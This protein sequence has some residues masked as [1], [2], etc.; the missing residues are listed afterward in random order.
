M[1]SSSMLLAVALCGAMPVLPIFAEETSSAGQKA[2]AGPEERIER[3]VNGYLSGIQDVKKN[4]S[5]RIVSLVSIGR[6]PVSSTLA[7][8]RA[9][10]QAFKRADAF[11]R[12]EFMKWLKTSVT[13]T[14]IDHHD[15]AIAEK[16]KSSG[17]SGTSAET[18]EAGEFT[19][20]SLEIVA[21]GFV[22]GMVQI[23]AGINDDNEAVVILGWN[24]DT[25]EQTDAIRDWNSTRKSKA[26]DRATG[27]EVKP[28][29]V[30]T[31]T[32]DA[33]GDFL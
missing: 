30:R 32:S 22:K 8:A 25:A 12:A 18:S 28:P 6:A 23:G 1:R 24:A 11:A 7:R 27:A 16:G 29:N 17:N 14:L 33:A 4:S 9:K 5:G 15:V 3:Y 10:S 13:Y 20:E 2:K 31:S 19:Q 21:S 26:A